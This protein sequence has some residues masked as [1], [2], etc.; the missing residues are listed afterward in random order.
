MGGGL[1]GNCGGGGAKL[2]RGWVK[3]KADWV[4]TGCS[5]H[6]R[7]ARDANERKG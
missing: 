3:L 1:R 6:G 7:G 2:D 5:G 4:V